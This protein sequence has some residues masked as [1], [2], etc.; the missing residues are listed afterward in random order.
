MGCAEFLLIFLE[1]LLAG[2]FK[3]G[4]GSVLDT[5]FDGEGREFVDPHR[6]GI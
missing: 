1:T 6:I 5:L 3:G 2:D 4:E